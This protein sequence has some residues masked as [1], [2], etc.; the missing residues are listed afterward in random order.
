MFLQSICIP[1]GAPEQGTVFIGFA[2]T[3]FLLRNLVDPHPQQG[4]DKITTVYFGTESGN[5]YRIH[6]IGPGQWEMISA[7][8]LDR[9][10]C[11][12]REDLVDGLLTCGKP[13]YYGQGAHSTPIKRIE[14]LNTSKIYLRRIATDLVESTLYQPFERQPAQ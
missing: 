1:Y 12:V 13:F 7:N 6:G 14:V 3:E 5:T 10:H 2:C 9:P 8:R 4:N 11:F